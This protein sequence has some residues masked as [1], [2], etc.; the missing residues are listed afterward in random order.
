MTTTADEK[1]DQARECVKV[2]CEALSDIVIGECHGHDQFVSGYTHMLSG[3]LIALL[4][5]KKEIAP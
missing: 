2:A 5:V 4:H 1:L 3:Q